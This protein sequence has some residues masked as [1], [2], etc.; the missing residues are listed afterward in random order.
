MKENFG[1]FGDVF[2]AIRETYDSLPKSARQRKGLKE[3]AVKIAA[4]RG[5][6]PNLEA[7]WPEVL[8]NTFSDFYE[9]KPSFSESCRL[10]K[11]RISEK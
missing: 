5:E 11:S 9:S 6:W 2:E 10:E 3:I 8:E 7:Y 4:F 1:N